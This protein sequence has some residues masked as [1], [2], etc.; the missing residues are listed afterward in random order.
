GGHHHAP[1]DLLELSL[2]NVGIVAALGEYFALVCKSKTPVEGVGR[3]GEN[4][5]GGRAPAATERSAAAVEKG[6]FDI[7]LGGRFVKLDLCPVERPS[8]REITSILGAVAVADHHHL[9]ISEPREIL[10]VG[11]GV[12]CSGDDVD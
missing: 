11:G 1:D 5:P 2:G 10:T 7:A 12:E 6:E 9:G 3:Q 8:G 4:R